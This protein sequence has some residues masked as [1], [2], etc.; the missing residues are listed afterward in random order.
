MTNPKV[1]MLVRI[2]KNLKEVF[3]AHCLNKGISLT[4][5]VQ[6]FIEEELTKSYGKLPA[7]PQELRRT[8]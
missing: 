3:Y 6:R 5:A 2:P 4:D 8:P 1:Q 7:H